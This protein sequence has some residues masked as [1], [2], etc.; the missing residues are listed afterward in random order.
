MN[1][2]FK[3]IEKNLYN[4]LLENFDDKLQEND[5]IIYSDLIRKIDKYLNNYLYLFEDNLDD[6]INNTKERNLGL[7]SIN[8]ALESLFDIKN[9][10]DRFN[11]DSFLKI[12]I[13]QKEQIA[14]INEKNQIEIEKQKIF[15]S[16]DVYKNDQNKKLIENVKEKLNTVLYNVP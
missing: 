13:N 12:L 6:I 8:K 11:F 14:N 4:L 2:Y 7:Q 16:L 15:D 5:Y 9:K 1:Y 3:P 10:F